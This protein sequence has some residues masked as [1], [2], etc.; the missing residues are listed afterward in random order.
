MS[1][2]KN[3]ERLRIAQIRDLEQEEKSVDVN[4]FID[5]IIIYTMKLTISSCSIF[6]CPNSDENEQSRKYA[7]RSPVNYLIKNDKKAVE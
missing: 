1:H 4:R 6:A 2:D 3:T 5:F 7:L